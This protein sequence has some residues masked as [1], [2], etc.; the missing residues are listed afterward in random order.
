MANI[1]VASVN[2]G[3]YAQGDLAVASAV[4]TVSD[5]AADP[6]TVKV[7]V[8]RPDSQRQTYTYTT[9]AQVVKDSTG[10]YHINLSCVVPGS[11]RV[12]WH[13]EGTGQAAD[14]VTFIVTAAGAAEAP[15]TPRN[16]NTDFF[17]IQRA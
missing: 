14:E 6:T 3:T 11:W 4:F 1:C 9:D 5:A 8:V 13:A 17:E 16:L 10:N 12:W 2:A 15:K 7:T